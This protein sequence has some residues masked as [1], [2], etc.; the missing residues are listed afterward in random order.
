MK[1]IR[2]VF[3]LSLLFV[4]SLVTYQKNAAAEVASSA[5]N[6][7][8]TEILE[9]WE[10]KEP[11]DSSSKEAEKELPKTSGSTGT[12]T[13][14]SGI[15]P[16]TGEEKAMFVVLIGLSITLVTIVIKATKQR[17]FK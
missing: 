3:L 7:V 13:K 6:K 14:K 5:D 15:L 10:P 11:V 12:A 17:K 2:K 4:F 16:Q 8:T 9:D 1:K